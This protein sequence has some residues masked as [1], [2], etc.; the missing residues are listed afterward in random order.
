MDSPADLP[1]LPDEQALLCGGPVATSGAD[2]FGLTL[3]DL[4][5]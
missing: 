3:E 2:I 4:P 5:F 1:D